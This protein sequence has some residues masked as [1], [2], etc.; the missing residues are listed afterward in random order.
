MGDPCGI[1][2]E[3]ILKTFRT[4]PEYKENSIVFGSFGL[5]KFYNDKF[6]M[7]YEFNKI[8]GMQD[9]K[10]GYINV[11]D[12][13]PVSIQD[14]TVG[15]VSAVGGRCAFMYV[16]TAI[17]FALR[18]EITSVVTA[19]LNKEALHLAGYNYAGHTEIFA[20]FTHGDSYAM[21]LWSDKLKVIHASTHVSLR[22]ACDNVNRQ[23][24]IDVLHL[25]DETL[26]KIGLKTMF[27]LL[28]T[29]AVGAI[30]GLFASTT[31]NLGT[32]FSL[33]AGENKNVPFKLIDA[34]Y[35]LI[36]S[37]IVSHAANNEVIQVIFFAILVAIAIIIE[38]TRHPERVKPFKDFIF[39]ASDIMN[40]LT[41]IVIRYTPYGVFGLAANAAARNDAA[42]FKT[43]AL[44][45]AVI[46]GVMMFH[47]IVIHLGLITFVAKLNPITFIKQVYPA[48][49]VALTT[50]SSLA[51]LPVTIKSLKQAG[52]SDRIANFSAPLGATMGMNACAGI[53]PAIVAVFTANAY[54]IHLGMPEYA[55]IILTTVIASIGIAG[56][57]GIASVVATVVLASVGLPLE[58]LLLVMGVEAFVD[59]G[60]TALNVTGAMVASTL[61]ARSEHEFDLAAFNSDASFD[62]DNNETI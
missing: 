2:A 45:I 16:K 19:P 48:Q 58:G 43:L 32:G 36:P 44:Y 49:V 39:S 42:A 4:K 17:D 24:T 60:R 8:E 13:Y 46:Y 25:A 33:P 57:P 34:L 23:R 50:Q 29:A 20:K 22:N 54:G 18:K 6:R 47:F 28:A 38:G 26:K 56:V 59:M 5:M 3:I 30:L 61:V 41:K 7:G 9:F 27:W 15:K 11:I 40:R 51:T 35:N 52:V 62:A 37:N 14:I 21:L 55:T 10:T 53:F 31:L 1:G 12:P